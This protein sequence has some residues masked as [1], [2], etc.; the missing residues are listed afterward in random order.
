MLLLFD[1]VL[2]LTDDLN[3][4][5][6]LN[7][8]DV[9]PQMTE[10][11]SV[12]ALPDGGAFVHNYV[13]VGS[14]DTNQVLRVNVT[15]QVI[16]HVYQCGGCNSVTGL[17]VLNNNLYVIHSDGALIQVDIK[18]TTIVRVY[19]VPNIGRTVHYGSLSYHPSVIT[20]PDLLLLADSRK[21]EIFSYNVTS[22]NKQVHL[23]GLRWPTSVSFMTY[24]S[25]LYYV[26]CENNRH[27][28]NIY[29]STW[30]S[31]QTLGGPGSGDGQLRYPDSAI[32]LPDGSVIIC[33][34]FNHRV[35][36]FNVH[37]RFIRH[38]LTWSDGLSY[39][40]AM[41]ISLPYLWLIDYRGLCRY[42]LY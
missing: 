5:L 15:G 7:M 20:H 19:Q 10:M 14:N 6:D 26:V 8:A 34:T 2:Y 40:G 1:F 39:P 17:L 29:N 18:N 30:S 27:Q 35:S 25:H 9:N 37:G 4:V 21:S 38:L 31:Y 3:P 16:Q 13:V 11:Y 12:A 28:V 22:K 41:S 33:D 24:N 32:G 23:T 42:K 36:L